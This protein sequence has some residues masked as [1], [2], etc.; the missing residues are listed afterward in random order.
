VRIEWD[1]PIA[2]PDG[3]VLRADVF[4]PDDDARHPVILSHGPY[5]K[6]LTFQQGY[7]DQ[8]RLLTAAH[9]DV[10]E[11]SSSRYQS[12]EV[13][14]PEQWVPHG[15]V[16]VRVDSRGAGRSPGH[17]D[18]WSPQEAS[19]FYEC[20]EW[21][22][23]QPWSNGKVGLNGISYYAINQWQV[24]SLQPPHLAAMC[25]WEGAADH[26]RDICYHGGIPSTFVASWYPAQV[27]VVQHGI[28]DRGPVNPNNDLTATGPETLGEEELRANRAD[29]GAQVAAHPFDDAFHRARSPDWSK[30]TV[31]FLSCAN[32]GGQGLHSRGNFEAFTQAA[33]S[34]K[35]LECHGLEHW[36]H[37]YT[38]Y[39]RE[40]QR[41][42]FDHFLKGE[43]NGWA[44]EPPVL[45]QV[46]RPGE[47]FEERRESS[48]PIERTRW[49]RL[50]LDAT[51]GSL[52]EDPGD[53]ASIAFAS[54]G[55]GVTFRLAPA[56]SEMEITGPLSAKL[57]VSSSTE[58]A[59]LYLV[60]H[61]FDPDGEE[62]H[63]QGTLDPHTPIAQ[64]WL[65][66]SHRRLDPERSTEARPYHVHTEREPL[67]PGAIY[68]LDV[69]IWP[70]SIVVPPGYRVALTVR[71]RDYEYGGEPVHVGWFEM[72]GCGPFTHDPVDHGLVTLHTGAGHPSSL[73]L[74]IVP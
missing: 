69:E 10:E 19:D 63:F 55:D 67:V 20:I 68:E 23:A 16:C 70:T 73:L 33:S 54:L 21:A 3:L 57:F 38:R 42:F 52:R 15:Y 65:R 34:R 74:P 11:G 18:C 22:G 48:W 32:W 46:R 28:G 56:A 17:L 6:G 4:R 31:P 66:A 14:D 49:T 58:D 35:W 9:P 62:V 13:V 64:G 47:R 71:G 26:Y 37:F 7:P 2:M 41:R 53:D 12:W 25:A 59:D 60:L 27:E 43:D 24:A 45:L 30:V 36:T 50:Y 1:V 40:L 61:V 72:R 39:G 29:L 51:G 8:W 44:R 5:A